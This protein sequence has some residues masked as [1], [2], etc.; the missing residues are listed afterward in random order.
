MPIATTR[1]PVACSASAAAIT[2]LMSSCEL[3]SVIKYTT[4]LAGSRLPAEGTRR[5]VR[6]WFSA[7]PVAVPQLR[8]LGYTND[9]NSSAT[10]LPTKLKS[11]SNCGSGIWWNIS[12]A[13][14]IAF[15]PTSSND[16]AS[17]TNSLA[18]S[19]LP[20]PT[21]PDASNVNSTS[22]MLAR[23]GK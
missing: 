10:T 2:T 3:P 13:T 19:K 16:T 9:R 20:W 18:M 21:L 15:S 22:D 12:P 23:Q 5:S 17:A 7:A 14:R 1:A 11:K 4:V 6:M 8:S